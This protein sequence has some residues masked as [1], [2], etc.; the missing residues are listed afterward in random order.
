M[1][2]DATAWTF[3]DPD[4]SDAEHRYITI[5]YSAKQRLL[6]VAHADES[7]DVIRIISARRAT[8]REKDQYGKIQ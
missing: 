1:F 2:L 4:H 6:F 8:S 5:G 7:D 3:Y